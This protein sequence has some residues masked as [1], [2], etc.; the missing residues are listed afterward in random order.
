MQNLAGADGEQIT[1]NEQINMYADP[2]AGTEDMPE[3]IITCL[4]FIEAVENEQY[5]WRW[6]CPK[7]ALKCKYRHMLPEGYVLCSKKEREANRK[8]AELD[9]E[10][11]MTI[12]EKIEEERAALKSD[13]LTP[14]TKE[15][16]DAWK[17]ARKEKKQKEA[18]EALVNSQVNAD[19]KKK[20]AKGKNSVMNGRALFSYNP[21]MFQD[22]DNAIEE[23]PDEEVDNNLFANEEV[24]EEDVD[25]D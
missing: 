10:N 16:F 25:F 6:E 7:G 2:R 5:G 1:K 3:T 4:D 20:A 24:K 8:Q 19:A 15:S 9:K 14:V 18:E 12:E 13:D 21:D 22:D 23:F 11:Q 17:A